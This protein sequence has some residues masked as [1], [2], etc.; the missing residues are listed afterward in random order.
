[1][2]VIKESGF[3]VAAFGWRYGRRWLLWRSDSSN[4]AK[5]PSGSVKFIKSKR[6][7]CYSGGTTALVVNYWGSSEF[8]I[9]SVVSVFVCA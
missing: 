6:W 4:K 3:S 7:R 9:V 8:E 5:E 2:A 1:M